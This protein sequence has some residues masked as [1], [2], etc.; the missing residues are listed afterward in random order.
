MMDPEATGK[1][2]GLTV[3]MQSAIGLAVLIGIVRLIIWL[4]N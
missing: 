2:V 1:K 3:A 4:C